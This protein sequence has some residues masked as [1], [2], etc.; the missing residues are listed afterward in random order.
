MLTG[1]D[2]TKKAVGFVVGAGTTRIVVGIIENNTDPEKLH[3]KAA[4]ITA[5]V[6]IGS[7]AK[8]ATQKYTDAKI[9]EIAAWWK[10]NISPRFHK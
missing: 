7:M 3:E 5:G 10:E 8:D 9:D 6:V 1:L 2:I 4:I